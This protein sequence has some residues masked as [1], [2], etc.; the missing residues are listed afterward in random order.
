MKRLMYVLVLTWMLLGVASDVWAACTTT[1]IFMPD[2]RMLIC[3]SC[4]YGSNCTVT[5]F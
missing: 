2:G 4:C 1:T 3:T 5:C